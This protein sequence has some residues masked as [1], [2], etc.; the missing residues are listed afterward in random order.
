[1]SSCSSFKLSSKEGKV[2][3]CGSCI[4]T[5]KFLLVVV[6]DVDD[7]EASRNLL[8]TFSFRSHPP[9]VQKFPLL[10]PLLEF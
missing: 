10:L 1:L 3:D 7:G 4:T 9:T 8:S 5:L 2:L 6:D